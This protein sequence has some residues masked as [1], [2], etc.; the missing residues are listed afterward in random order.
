MHMESEPVSENKPSK[1]CD[2]LMEGFQRV[3]V[4]RPN[5]SDGKT[6]QYGADSDGA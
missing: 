4:A 3:S 2:F 5:D 1:S 6:L